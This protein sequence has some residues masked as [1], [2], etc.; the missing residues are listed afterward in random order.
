MSSQRA[1]SRAIASWIAGSA[2]SMP[3]SVS[4]ENTTP[5]PKVSSSALRSQTVMSLLGVELLGERREVQSAR[6][7]AD[8]RDAHRAG[9]AVPLV[10]NAVGSIVGA[11]Q[12]RGRRWAPPRVRGWRRA[13]LGGP[14]RVKSKPLNQAPAP[15]E[16]LNLLCSLRVAA[17]PARL[18]ELV[19]QH[20]FPLGQDV[21]PCAAKRGK[22]SNFNGFPLT[23]P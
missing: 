17:L 19:D 6:A 23:P 1:N 22:L 7:A 5:N 2:C 3:P 15:R 10:Q 11:S 8:D 12:E 13:H 16:R 21:S 18:F 20:R 4:S 14:G 9:H